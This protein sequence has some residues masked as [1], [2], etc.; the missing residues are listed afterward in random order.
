MYLF[1]IIFI[2]CQTKRSVKAGSSHLFIVGFL[3]PNLVPVTRDLMKSISDCLNE[4][5]GEL[6][7]LQD[8]WMSFLTCL[9]R[10]L[11][12]DISRI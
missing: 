6:T 11:I 8:S 1:N 10:D 3:V 2:L 12:L 9:L 5:V 4:G 7:W